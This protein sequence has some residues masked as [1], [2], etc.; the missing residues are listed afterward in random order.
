MADGMAEWQKEWQNGRMVGMAIYVLF[1][2]HADTD[3]D[4]DDNDNDTLIFYSIDQLPRPVQHPLPIVVFITATARLFLPQFHVPNLPK[5][6]LLEA[7][8][9]PNLAFLPV[10]IP[11][12]IICI[13]LVLP[14][15]PAVIA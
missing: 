6:H 2:V 13:V 4:D 15:H 9:K 8:A 12:V 11:I 5:V 3:D 14:S 7:V 10:F 1:M